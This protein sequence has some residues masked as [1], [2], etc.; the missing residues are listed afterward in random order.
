MRPGGYFKWLNEISI[1]EYEVTIKLLRICHY[2]DKNEHSHEL[3]GD[4]IL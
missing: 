1:F 2:C 4:I 3:L